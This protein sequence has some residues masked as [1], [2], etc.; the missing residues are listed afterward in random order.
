MEIFVGRSRIQTPSVYVWLFLLFGHFY[1]LRV[2]AGSLPGLGGRICFSPFSGG[3]FW[4]TLGG[5][6]FSPSFEWGAGAWY[7]AVRKKWVRAAAGKFRSLVVGAPISPTTIFRPICGCGPTRASNATYSN[8]PARNYQLASLLA[9]HMLPA[10]RRVCPAGG[11][12]FSGHGFGG[13]VLRSYPA[14]LGTGAIRQQAMRLVAKRN[15]P[16]RDA[17][18]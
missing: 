7:G 6:M 4:L 17:I 15:S 9:L 1:F 12:D 18:R 10:P 3:S 16:A 8:S 5:S 14:P 2:K 13:D 11:C